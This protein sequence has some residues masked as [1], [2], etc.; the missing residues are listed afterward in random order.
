M[1]GVGMLLSIAGALVWS[2]GAFGSSA[3]ILSVD[4]RS[5][6]SSGR[7]TAKV[8]VTNLTDKTLSVS[9][10]GTI[11]DHAAGKESLTAGAKE[12]RGSELVNR[13]VLIE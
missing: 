2:L 6:I 8:V 10:S 1:K 3:R 5:E 11:L 9:I 4:C 13:V 7:M 12:G